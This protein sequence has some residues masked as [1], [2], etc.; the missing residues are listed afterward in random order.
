MPFCCAGSIWMMSPTVARPEAWSA[1]R[2]RIV[3]GAG[4]VR[5]LRPIVEPV[6][7]MT[8][9]LDSCSA[10]FANSSSESSRADCTAAAG[11]AGAGSV[12]GGVAGSVL[13]GSDEP[14]GLST[15]EGSPS[16]GG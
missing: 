6:M 12:A 3:S 14:S 1:S 5:F 2:L 8:S 15:G 9:S 4:V 16:A 10:S 11:A 7:M 13:A